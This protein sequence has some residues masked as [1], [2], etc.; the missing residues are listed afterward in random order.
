MVSSK[1]GL[2]FSNL[3]GK[4]IGVFVLVGSDVFQCRV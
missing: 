3:I 2:N 4:I 1:S